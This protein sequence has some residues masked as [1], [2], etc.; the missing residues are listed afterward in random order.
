MK[1]PDAPRS[2]RSPRRWIIPAIQASFLLL[3]VGLHVAGLMRVW[4]FVLVIGLVLSPLS[5]RLYCRAAWNALLA[6]AFTGALLMGLRF[7]F[8]TIITVVGVILCRVL[9]ASAWCN[10]LCPWGALMRLE[11]LLFRRRVAERAAP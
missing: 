5:R 11:D 8:F 4:L 3:F 9:P 6:A 7:Y 2:T 1:T 10:G